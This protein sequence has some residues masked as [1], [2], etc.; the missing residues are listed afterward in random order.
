MTK[1]A[2]WGQFSENIY[3]YFPQYRS[4]VTIRI[5][6]ALQMKEEYMLAKIDFCI[7]DL[8]VGKFSVTQFVTQFTHVSKHPE[9]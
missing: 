9:A 4:S 6:L 1:L 8:K 2:Q 3:D 7:F 5:F